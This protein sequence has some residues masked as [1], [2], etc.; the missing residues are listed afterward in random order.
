MHLIKY[1]TGSY[2]EA[3][4]QQGS[5]DVT[6]KFVSPYVMTNKQYVQ[7][8]DSRSRMWLLVGVYFKGQ[9]YLEHC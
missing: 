6:L 9:I 4:G 7:V 8:K 1:D 2:A 5:S 3:L